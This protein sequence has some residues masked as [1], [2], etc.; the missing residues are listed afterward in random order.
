MNKLAAWGIEGIGEIVPG[1]QVGDILLGVSRE[2]AKLFLATKWA[3]S[4]LM[5]AAVNQMAL[6]K[7]S[8]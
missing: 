6:C 7:T 3:T 2:S 5:L 4:S 1:D 8:T